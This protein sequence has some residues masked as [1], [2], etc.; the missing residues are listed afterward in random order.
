MAMFCCCSIP[1]TSSLVQPSIRLQSARGKIVIPVIFT[2]LPVGGDSLEFT[3]A[4]T[5]S[6]PVGGHLIPFGYRVP[7]FELGVRKGAV[8]LANELLFSWNFYLVPIAM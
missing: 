7:D 3:C 1:S 5:V 4:G 6:S 2:R 8:H